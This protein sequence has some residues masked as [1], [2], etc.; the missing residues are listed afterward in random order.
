M[1][2]LPIGEDDGIP[3]GDH[4]PLRGVAYTDPAGKYPWEKIYPMGAIVTHNPD[5]AGGS[6]VA[7]MLSFTTIPQHLWE[8]IT[9]VLGERN[10]EFA[11]CVN[12]GDPGD[13]WTLD[14][15]LGFWFVGQV[16]GGNE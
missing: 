4:S 8:D 5:L 6:W 2:N 12:F 1:F 7:E 15:E 10:P 11:K 9:A 14:S 16:K 13:R 3:F